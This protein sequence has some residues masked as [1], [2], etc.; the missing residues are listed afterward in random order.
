MHLTLPP[1]GNTCAIHVEVTMALETL[2]A[3]EARIKGLVEVVQELKRINTALQAELRTTRERLM[4]QEELSRRWE[5]ERGDIRTRIEK[6][7]GDLDFLECVEEP[8][9]EVTRRA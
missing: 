9:E 2:Q 3:L 7:L 6:V 4:K 1:A 8:S 5:E